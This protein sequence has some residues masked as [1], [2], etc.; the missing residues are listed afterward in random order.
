[1]KIIGLMAASLLVLA[2]RAEG[3]QDPR[4]MVRQS[5]ARL[6]ESNK[7]LADYGFVRRVERR[8]FTSGGALKSAQSWV[9]RR[10]FQDGFQVHRLLERDGRPVPEEERRR[11]EEAIAK[12]LAELKAMTPEQRQKMREE[13]QRKAGDQDAWLK[14]FPEALDYRLAG[15]E[16]IDGR[17]AWVLEC[18]PRSGYR[19]KNMRARVFQKVRGRIWIDKEE[20]ELAR[21]EAEVF[22][23]VPVGWGLLG[24]I[25]KGTRFFLERKKVAPGTWFT[26]SEI[27]KFAA[28]VMLVKSLNHEISTRFSDFR[29]RGGTATGGAAP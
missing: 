2:G 6:E 28:R 10:E 11:S 25:D 27:V 17:P 21:V 15:E 23:T 13:R 5:L 12:R 9:V 22:E 14:E 16:T 20:S 18:S 29:Q 26:E 3:P 1:M 19:P 4:A 24:R 7:K 8:Q